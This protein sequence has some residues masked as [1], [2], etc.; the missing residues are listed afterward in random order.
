MTKSTLIASVADRA[1]VTKKVAADVLEALGNAAR[2][3]LKAKEEI[4]LP[5]IG[6]LRLQHKA[7]RRGI[8]PATK[9]AY[10]KAA[11]NAVKLKVTKELADAVA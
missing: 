6:K 5:G 9:Q 3:G 1:G 11:H 10:V 4:T 7:E 8:S 2:D